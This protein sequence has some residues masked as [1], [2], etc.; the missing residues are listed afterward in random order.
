MYLKKK[1]DKRVLLILIFVLEYEN[2]FNTFSGVTINNNIK[3]DSHIFI[4]KK[5]NG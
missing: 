2:N 1:L 5:Q 4:L 3:W